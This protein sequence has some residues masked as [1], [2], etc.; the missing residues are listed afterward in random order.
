METNYN[1]AH[2]ADVFSKTKSHNED[3]AGKYYG[4]SSSL[5]AEH[6]ASVD[7]DRRNIA[8]GGIDLAIFPWE[9]FAETNDRTYKTYGLS[10]IFQ[11]M[12]YAL[13][14]PSSVLICGADYSQTR[15]AQCC[16]GGIKTTLLNNV[17]LDNFERCFTSINQRFSNLEYDVLTM[18]DLLSDDCPKFDL[19]EVW[20]N[21]VDIPPSR[22]DDLINALNYSGVILVN[23][24]SDWGFLYDN[25]TYGHPMHDLHEELKNNDLV[26]VYHI[27]LHY[28]FTLVIKHENR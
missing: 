21:Q 2:L 6:T 12:I 8:T 11:D 1:L 10:Q 14:N 28:G 24:T 13:K 19:I 23:G 5:M 22:A 3:F 26:S 4:Y 15:V 20:A 17:L 25:E 18:Q 27:P 7:F 9:M 16:E